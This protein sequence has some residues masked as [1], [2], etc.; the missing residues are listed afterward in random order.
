[1]R[2]R[3]FCKHLRLLMRY[4]VLTFK[5]FSAYTWDMYLNMVQFG[6][7]MVRSLV[8]WWAVLGFIGAFGGWGLPELALFTA[9]FYLPGLHQLVWNFWNRA[10][11]SEK[12]LRGDL[13]KYLA[14]PLSPLFALAAEDVHV[15][16][17][18]RYLLPALALA[19]AIIRGYGLP[20]DWLSFA[21]GYL[22]LSLGKLIIV[23]MRATTAMLAF[24][25][26][27]VSQLGNLFFQLTRLGNYP[28]TVFPGPL[29]FF[30]TY[31][32]PAGLT[33]TY[34]TL[35][36]LGRADPGPIVGAAA[37]ICLTWIL[38]LGQA[39]GRAV[40]AYDSPGG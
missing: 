7:Y 38:V 2:W 17:F 26:G 16:L 36:M 34:P 39:W 6:L 20:V 27:E 18:I 3:L 28:V 40:R 14:R 31:V 12:V 1:V 9:V 11:L 35:V 32:L 24:R 33:A 21:L 10:S 30:L 13:D 4:W 22:V 8:F 29:Q 37:A 19:I 25:H 15:A 5:D 23:L